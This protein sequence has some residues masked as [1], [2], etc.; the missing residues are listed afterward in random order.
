MLPPHP[1]G[2]PD[3]FSATRPIAASQTGS[4]SL[5]G[6]G[7]RC[8]GQVWDRR[9]LT[10][11]WLLRSDPAVGQFIFVDNKQVKHVSTEA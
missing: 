4:V 3:S 6:P 5:L 1:R 9:G 2:V 11:L 10:A 7:C 8:L